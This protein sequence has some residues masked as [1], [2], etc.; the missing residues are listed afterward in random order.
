MGVV[1]LLDDKV[2]AIKIKPKQNE[3]KQQQ[4]QKNSNTKYL[5]KELKSFQYK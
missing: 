5:V 3:I 1:G 2:Q 4:Q